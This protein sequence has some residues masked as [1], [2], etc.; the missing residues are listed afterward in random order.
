[1]CI[2]ID[3]VSQHLQSTKVQKNNSN[4]Y[5]NEKVSRVG[6]VKST[7]TRGEVVVE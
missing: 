3:V 5:K 6:G 2:N 1:M 4:K 7:Q